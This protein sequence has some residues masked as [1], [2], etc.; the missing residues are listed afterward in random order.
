MAPREVNL[1]AF[2]RLVNAPLHRHSNFPLP[3]QSQKEKL[4]NYVSHHC[5]FNSNLIGQIIADGV[6]RK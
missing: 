5:L 2:F 1:H 6:V 3:H 4:P